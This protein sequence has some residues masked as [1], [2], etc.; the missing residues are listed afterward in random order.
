MIIL[1]G[2]L[3]PPR[4]K[5]TPI[6]GLVTL[7]PYEVRYLPG[8]DR[9]SA[10]DGVWLPAETIQ[11]AFSTVVQSTGSGTKLLKIDLFLAV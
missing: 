10:A 11:R 2:L 3:W 9:G 7:K 8:E 4:W 5:M 1:R 6:S